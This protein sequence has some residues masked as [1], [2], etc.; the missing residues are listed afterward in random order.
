MTQT[1]N[2]PKI[3]KGTAIL[4]TVMLLI[5][6]VI[7]NYIYTLAVYV[8]PLS[9]AHGW[10]PNSIVM[11]YSMAM[12]CEIPAFLV[13]GWCCS[14]YGTKKVLTISGVLYGLA[15]LGSGLVKSVTMFIFFQGIIGSLAMYGV[16]IATIALVN[17]LFPERKGLVMGLFYGSQACGSVVFAPIAYICIDHFNVSIALVLQGI[18]F[19]V[20]MF[21]CCM[22]V[23]DPTGGNKEEMARL[24]AEAEA[25]EAEAAMAG[26]AEDERPTMGWKKAFCHPGFWMFFFSIIALQLIG[27]VLLTD[28][29]IIA[30]TQYGV[31][32][33]DGAWIVSAFSIGAGIGGVLIGMMSDKIGPYQ[34]SFWLGLVDGV[35]L[36]LLALLGGDN[37]LFYGI[38]VVIQGFTYNGI[39]TLNPL[40]V[41]DTYA[42]KDLGVIMSGSGVAIMI[43]GFAGPQLGLMMPFVP[44]V[45]ICAVLSVIGG[46]LA[47]M[48][49]KSF[50]KY[51]EGIG[52]KCKVR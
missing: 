12:V 32:E 40:M 42:S 16:F 30:T 11:A 9:S 43:V 14:K 33:A 28:M 20:I 15:I 23:K 38:I 5:V 10:S 49:A 4:S 6:G 31:S 45:M 7:S 18:L 26:K 3:S 13:G 19:T 27:N 17:V 24:Q 8:E 21:V 50:N 37:F 46:F 39:T 41:T 1:L 36:L 34:T 35:L 29:S 47:K 44:M 2:T 51:Y 52:S 22:L 48:S 25:A